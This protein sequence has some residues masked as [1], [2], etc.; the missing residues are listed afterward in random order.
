MKVVYLS[1]TTDFSELD[2]G[3]VEAKNQNKY[4]IMHNFKDKLELVTSENITD[5]HVYTSENKDK[6]FLCVKSPQLNEA[7]HAICERL[8]KERG[9]VFRP[10]RDVYYI[11]M[12]PEKANELPRNQQLNISINVYGVFYQ[13][14]SKNSFLQMELTGYKEYPLVH[15]Q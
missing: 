10:E 8:N 2:L 1:P 11:R 9:H 6:V 13:T 7:L 15:F 3:T 5:Y 4:G 14:S 12:D